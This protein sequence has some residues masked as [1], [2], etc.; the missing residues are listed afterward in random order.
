MTDC[1]FCKIRDKKIAAFVIYEDKRALAFLDLMP[2]APGHTLVVP[3][4]HAATITDLPESEIQPLFSAVRKVVGL[5]AKSLTPDG[6]TVGIN[7]GEASGQVV[8]H[9]HVH[10]MP[11]FDGDGGGAVQSV[12]HNPPK[13]SLEAIAQKIK[14][15]NAKIKI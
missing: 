3:K 6:V 15:Q 7:Q 14:N 12:V 2:R 13:E 5:L 9:L 8:G 4:V 10:V 11:R 1:L